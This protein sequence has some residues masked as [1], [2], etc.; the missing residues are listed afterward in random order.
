MKKTFSRGC[1]PFVALLS[2][3]V[4]CGIFSDKSSIKILSSDWSV[5]FFVAFPIAVLVGNAA[6]IVLDSLFPPSDA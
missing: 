3:L 1:A 4:G 5:F 6:V 2:V